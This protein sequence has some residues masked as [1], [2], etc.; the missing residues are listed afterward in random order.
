MS[1]IPTVEQPSS[2]REDALGVISYM[3]DKVSEVLQHIDP[4]A[5]LPSAKTIKKGIKSGS[6]A[7]L[8]Y[9]MGIS[10]VLPLSPVEMDKKLKKYYKSYNLSGFEE[11]A[12][13]AQDKLAVK[14]I[15][16]RDIDNNTK[17]VDLFTLGEI[18]A[19]IN[20][21]VQEGSDLAKDRETIER[22]LGD[23]NPAPFA[24]G[25]NYYAKLIQ[26]IQDNEI[27]TPAQVI[28]AMQKLHDA[29]ISEF[30]KKKRDVETKLQALI[31]NLSAPLTSEQEAFARLCNIDTSNIGREQK[32][33]EKVEKLIKDIDE[34]Y[35]KTKKGIEEQYAGTNE[36]GDSIPGIKEKLQDERE[37]SEADLIIRVTHLEK[38]EK[39]GYK[40]PDLSSELGPMLTDSNIEGVDPEIRA[41]FLKGKDM[42]TLTTEEWEGRF[43]GKISN[44]TVTTRRGT[45]I[46]VEFAPDGTCKA[47]SLE[48]APM[49]IDLL[50]SGWREKMELNLED[51][52]LQIKA[53]NGLD[54][55][56][57]LTIDHSV[58]D[59]RR[60]MVR[61]TYRAA[62]KNGY[63]PEDIRFTV[64]G[65]QEE[66]LNFTN[67][68]ALEV[69]KSLGIPTD[70]PDITKHL[71]EVK[72]LRDDAGKKLQH[73]MSKKIKEMTKNQ[74]S[75]A[76][77]GNEDNNEAE[78]NSNP[79][80]SP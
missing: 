80:P 14:P 69:L 62:L 24:D 74:N 6:K 77:N 33:A 72:K 36:D 31:P 75:G 66:K 18:G 4:S 50:E 57:S 25:N 55:G 70:T 23:L 26:A 35:Q 5:L 61:A 68:P 41:K 53:T 52:I 67:K 48:I 13:N 60:E 17:V 1:Q 43:Y 3:G 76:N 59:N 65:S 29:T 46:K 9:A 49:W 15:A 54:A 34:K 22:H 39:N 51:F 47:L 20:V 32:I 73:N 63:R 38:M 11:L 71:T 79:S 45:E 8:G 21:A 27:H 16:I 44:N 78:E 19:E 10:D 42:Q 56:L 64:T 12:T 2:I 40:I 7:A 28:D 37:K 58:D 30:A